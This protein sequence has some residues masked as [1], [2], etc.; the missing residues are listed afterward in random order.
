MSIIFPILQL[1]ELRESDLLAKGHL[2]ESQT[3]ELLICSTLYH[4]TPAIVCGVWRSLWEFISSQFLNVS[5]DFILLVLLA[6]WKERI[7]VPLVRKCK[8]L[9][10]NWCVWG[11]GAA[12]S[13]SFLRGAGNE[14][15]VLKPCLKSSFSGINPTGFMGTRPSVSGDYYSW[16]GG[17][18][19]C[20]KAQTGTRNMSSKLYSWGWGCMG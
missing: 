2:D 1:G 13:S 16:K 3:K 18:D 11:G 12:G 9:W 15:S 4:V 8:Y 17:R 19:N 20:N 5:S 10:V 6:T 14:F 7:R